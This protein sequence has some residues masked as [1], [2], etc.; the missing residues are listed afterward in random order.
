M[1]PERMV[2][3]PRATLLVVAIAVL[4]A[5]AFA[6]AHPLDAAAHTNDEPCK[7]CLGLSALGSANVAKT[8]SFCD[9]GRSPRPCLQAPRIWV[10]VA[11]VP[12]RARGP[13]AQI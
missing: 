6:F 8:P 10:S 2:R 7:I 3:Q 4:L 1:T 12:H 11:V 5:E 13:P 9:F